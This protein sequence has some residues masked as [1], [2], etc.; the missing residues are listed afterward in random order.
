[1]LEPSTMQENMTLGAKGD[2][3]LVEN[4][5]KNNEQSMDCPMLDLEKK[6]LEKELLDHVANSKATFKSQQKE[7]P[8][9]TFEEKLAI[10]RKLLEKS[11]CLF[12]SK[13]GQYMKVEHLEYFNKSQDYETIYHVNR[14]QRYFNNSTRHIDIRNRRYEALKTLIEKGEYFSECEMMKRNPLLYEHLVGQYL[15]DEEKKARDS[16]DTKSINYVDILMETVERNKLENR[17]KFQQKEEDEIREENDSDEDY[18]NDDNNDNTTNSIISKTN[19]EKQNYQHWGEK[20]NEAQKERDKNQKLQ[21]NKIFKISSQEIKL[22]RQEFVTNMYQSFLD[23]KDTDFDYSTV[24]DN[25]A[26]DNVDLRNQ[27]EE[28]KYFDSEAPETVLPCNECNDQNESEDELD[29]YMKSLKERI[30]TNP[31][32]LDN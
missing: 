15:T 9:L 3:L 22:L 2:P 1:M 13:F 29:I 23:G 25:E 17:L 10:V 11:H 30:P 24:D 27:D 32:S 19:F 4:T 12:L 16:I 14:L 8:E 20:L 18:D 21:S 28:E 7:E 31:H 6:T 5:N 26:Y